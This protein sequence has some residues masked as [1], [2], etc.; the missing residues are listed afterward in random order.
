MNNYYL[1]GILAL[2]VIGVAAGSFFVLSKNNVF[3]INSLNTV[4]NGEKKNFSPK[5]SPEEPK[6]KKI[7]ENNDI[8][9]QKPLINP[10]AIIKAVYFTAWS[11][12]NSKKIDYLIDLAKKT[13]INAVVIDIKDYSGYVA[14]DINNEEVEKYKAKKIMIP[15]INSL[16]KK[17]HDE[18]IYVIARITVFQDP[19]LAKARPDLAI[20]SK[21]KCQMSDVECQMSLSTLW[22]DHKK[23]AWVD[24]AAREAW[25]YNVAIAKDAASR[26]FDELNFD[27]IR[28][29]SDGDLNDMFFPFWD[30]KIPKNKVIKKFFK[31][32]RE[33]LH[34]VKISADLFG[35]A[36]IEK[37]DLGIGQIIED[38]FDYFDYVSPM[39]YPSHYSAGFFGYKNPS[40][41][42][43]ETVKYSM[44]SA[45]ERLKIYRGGTATSS[46]SSS[47]LYPKFRPWLQDFDL[48]AD[49]DA[50]KVR[51]Q[52]RASE[53]SGGFGWL[54]WNPSNN[55]TL[56][57]LLPN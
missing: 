34:N 36:V 17:L 12:G 8:E 43:Y 14:Y 28:F 41:Y 37:N 22:L 29:A 2:A 49:Y 4:D 13:E 21:T 26:G 27:Y 3:E 40:L 19:I 57:A 30:E 44:T 56:E 53:E 42:P 52:I 51:A 31:Y 7:G 1:S 32:L 9:P 35:V 38:S 45:I 10:P 6:N 55:Y 50:Q 20:H 39:I 25:T 46:I 33:E 16:L 5:E 47:S 23:L 18:G 54:L 11:A 48:G 24:P 15:K